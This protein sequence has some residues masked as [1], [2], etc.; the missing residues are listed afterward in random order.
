MT[1]FPFPDASV[2]EAAAWFTAEWRS[3]AGFEFYLDH[4]VSDGAIFAHQFKH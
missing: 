1:V 2:R 4:A 3:A